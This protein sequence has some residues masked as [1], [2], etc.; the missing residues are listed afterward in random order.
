MPELL[1]VLTNVLLASDWTWSCAAQFVFASEC[2]CGGFQ[3]REQ[4]LDE[5]STQLNEGLYRLALNGADREPW[6]W[7]CYIGRPKWC[8]KGL[9]G[10]A[11]AML[12]D[13]EEEASRLIDQ[14]FDLQKTLDVLTWQMDGAWKF[15]PSGLLK[16]TL[17]K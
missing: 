16:N 3:K 12:V 2:I 15:P 5:Q 11:L 6:E 8:S 14:Y 1:D 13:E 7:V 4:W 17:L 9:I 10:E